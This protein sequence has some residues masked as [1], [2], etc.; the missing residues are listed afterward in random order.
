MEKCLLLIMT[1]YGAFSLPGGWGSRKTHKIRTPFVIFN[2]IVLF[3]PDTRGRG[4]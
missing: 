3:K 1:L 2:E 4:V